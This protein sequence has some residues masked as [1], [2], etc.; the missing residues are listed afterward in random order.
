MSKRGRELRALKYG[1]VM[2]LIILSAAAAMANPSF[3]I[4]SNPYLTVFAYPH[5]L[6]RWPEQGLVF[7]LA[8]QTLPWQGDVT[9]IFNRPSVSYTSNYQSVEFAVPYDYEGSPEDVR[10]YMEVSSYAYR[11]RYGAG[12]LTTAGYGKFLFEVGKTALNMELAAQGVAR[13]YEDAGGERAYILV[14]FD[15]ET[16]AER[17]DLDFKVTYAHYLFGNPVGLKM[18]YTHFSSGVPTGYI[19]FTRDGE[20]YHTPH[21]TWGWATT[22]CN[23]IFGYSHINADAFYQNTYTVYGGRQWD[24]QASFELKGNYKSG[25]RYRSCRDDGDTYR[26][27]YDEGSE[28]E[29]DYYADEKWMDRKTSRLLRGYSKV[30]FYKVGD[31]DLG[32][33]FFLELDSA[34]QAS[35]NKLVESDPTSSEN[36]TGFAIETNP[37]F[38]YAYGG[39]YFDFGLLLEVSRT[40]MENT[41]TR[42][43]GVSG[44]DEKDVLWSTS[45]YMGWSPYWEDF[46][47]GSSWFFAT[48]FE[49][50]SSIGVYRRLSVLTR[51]TV[52]KKYTYTTKIYGESVIPDGGNSYEFAKSHERNDSR[53]ET[54]MTG[55]IGFMYGR[56]PLQV[57]ADLQ[58]P[59]AYL[60]KQSTKLSDNEKVLFEH[61]ENSMWQVQEPVALRLMFV[62]AL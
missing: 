26:W 58:M 18:H 3:T 46:S 24:L 54:W 43:N 42:W 15:G 19:R 40:G 34:R 62:Y 37:F 25:I 2:P 5:D 9:N 27:K 14:P 45:P 35:V 44:T 52:L 7:N 21:L 36:A 11:T 50:Y 4:G 20:T 39:G 47:K 31:M 60:V 48:G 17:D 38:N 8:P 23:H 30:R 28:Y 1:L 41:R 59:L 53:D 61:R 55:S 12:G 13:T 22:G 49:A 6:L 57:M 16:T 51:L 32:V 33:L 10:S 56:G 29:G